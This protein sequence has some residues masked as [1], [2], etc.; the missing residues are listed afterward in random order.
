MREKRFIAKKRGDAELKNDGFYR[1][2]LSARNNIIVVVLSSTQLP[3]FMSEFGT[4]RRLWLGSRESPDV[5]I[6]RSIRERYSYRNILS[7]V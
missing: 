2:E 3:S 6:V 1:R 7:K 5:G 4:A